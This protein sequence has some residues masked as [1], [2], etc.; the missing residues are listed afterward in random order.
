MSPPERAPLAELQRRLFDLIVT[1]PGGEALSAAERGAP[2]AST[3]LGGCDDAIAR[4]ARVYR[5]GYFA[6]LHDVLAGDFECVRRVVGSERFRALVGDYLSVHPSE[7]PS[8]RNAGARLPELVRGHPLAEQ[9]PFLPELARLERARVEAFDAPNV[10]VLT[11]HDLAG[12]PPAWT[13]APLAPVPAFRALTVRYPVDDAW[14]VIDRDRDRDSD[15][16]GTAVALDALFEPRTILVWRRDLRVYH[17][18]ASSAREAAALAR[19]AAGGSFADA[20]ESYAAPGETH[21]VGLDGA[22]STALAALSR[23]VTD[24]ILAIPG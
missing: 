13:T 17:R 9:W 22:A 24:G 4:G 8:L 18:A 16:A 3:W 6:R 15:A 5:T 12:L 21:D 14:V 23:W 2:A 19:L 1:S 7:E 11:L 20:C 10:E